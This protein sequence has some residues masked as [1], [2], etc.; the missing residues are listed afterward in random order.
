MSK[1]ESNFQEKFMSWFFRGKGI[2]KPLNTGYIDDHVRCIREFSANIFFYTKNDTTIMIDAGYNYSR[3]EEKMQWLELAP[4]DIHHIL[5][6]HQDTDHVGAVESDSALLFEH[7][8]LYIGEIENQYLTGEKYRKVYYGLETLPKVTIENPIKLLQDG[9]VLYIE[10]IKIECILVPGHTW[11]H[12]VYLIDDAYLF[13]GDTLWLGADGGYSFLNV[14]AENNKLAKKSLA[15]L[16]ENLKSR[17]LN[18]IIITGHTG[19]TDDFDFAF[20]HINKS[21]NAWVKQKPR[22]ENAPYDAYDETDDIPQ[23][24]KNCRLP[25][26][27]SQ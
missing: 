21:C 27:K 6:T 16:K 1:E 24:V 18:P 3:L 23:N 11:G 10:D 7:A 8:Q 20:A 25:K 9:D 22:D 12:L 26:Q 17:H 13:T 19:Y 14:L 4:E 2:F 5:L 15:M